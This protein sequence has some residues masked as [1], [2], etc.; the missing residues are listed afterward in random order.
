MGSLSWAVFVINDRCT[1]GY[2]LTSLGPTISV[3]SVVPDAGDRRQATGTVTVA[4][5]LES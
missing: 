3:A 1:P 5:S 2:V 4:S